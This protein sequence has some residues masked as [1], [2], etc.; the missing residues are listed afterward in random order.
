MFLSLYKTKDINTKYIT[1]KIK[2]LFLPFFF[3]WI[4]Y[5]LY[6][7]ITNRTQFNQH[8]LV[9]FITLSLP[10]GIDAWFFKVIIGLYISII[11]LFKLPFTNTIRVI[12]MFVLFFAY[13]IIMRKLL[14]GP[15]WYNS[16][17]CF[18]LGMLFACSKNIIKNNYYSLLIIVCCLILSLSTTIAFFPYITFA[19]CAVWCVKI[20]N[21]KIFQAYSS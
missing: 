8:L 4:V 9:E 1:N 20:I 14:F 21:I 6:F 3:T 15:W 19:V 5:L 16:V 17:V 10:N 13:Y 18:P 7:L 2:K 12:I 11:L